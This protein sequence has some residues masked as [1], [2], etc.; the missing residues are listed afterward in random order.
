MGDWWGE[1]EALREE[2]RFR[3]E[4]LFSRAP[5]DW[6]E[7]LFLAREHIRIGTD[8]EGANRELHL[9]YALRHVLGVLGR[10]CAR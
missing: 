1:R 10:L 5:E 6:R 7:P 3:V 9:L 4:H 2:V 8:P